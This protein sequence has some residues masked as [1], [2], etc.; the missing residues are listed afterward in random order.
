MKYDQSSM[1]L[2]NYYRRDIMM[3]VDNLKEYRRM[4]KNKSNELYLADLLK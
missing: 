4:K 1:F 2:W 3:L